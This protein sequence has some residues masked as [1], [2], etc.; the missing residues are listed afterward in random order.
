M[1]REEMSKEG[2]LLNLRETSV[3]SH[4]QH[5][6]DFFLKI[7]KNI[8]IRDTNKIKDVIHQTISFFF[9]KY[10]F[11]ELLQVAVSCQP[12]TIHLQLKRLTFRYNI[13]YDMTHSNLKCSRTNVMDCG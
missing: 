6:V 9:K 1:K 7:N 12:I 4:N 13:L 11:S 2:A 5:C 8:G 10:Y 3:S